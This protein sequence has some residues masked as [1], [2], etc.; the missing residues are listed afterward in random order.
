MRSYEF[1]QDKH[2]KKDDDTSESSSS[3]SAP[4]E[5]PRE[6]DMSHGGDHT[7]ELRPR[8]IEAFSLPTPL[9]R[10][11]FASDAQH[12]ET[13]PDAD[14]P[15]SYEDA[16]ALSHE[17]SA[18]SDEANQSDEDDDE[19]GAPKTTSS[20][21]TEHQTP[22]RP[23]L[24]HASAIEQIM[25]RLDR[26]TAKEGTADF[27][28]AEQEPV[29]ADHPVAEQPAAAPP[30]QAESE[31]FFLPNPGPDAEAVPSV[32]DASDGE[33]PS[34][35]PTSAEAYY[36]P[37]QP[38]PTPQP[39]ADVY[40]Y[41]PTFAQ[42]EQPAEMRFSVAPPPG[43]TVEQ[44]QA[45][46]NDASRLGEKRG[47]RRGLVVGLTALLIAQHL[48]HRKQRRALEQIDQRDKHINQL[49]T[50]Q[51][52]TAEQLQAQRQANANANYYGQPLQAAS[53][54]RP[55]PTAMFNQTPLERAPALAAPRPATEFGP[56]QP[57]QRPEAAPTP[58]TASQEQQAAEHQEGEEIVLQPGQHLERRGWYSVV[59]DEHGREVQ[60]AIQYGEAFQREQRQEQPPVSV[61][62]QTK[63]GKPQ[64][65][66]SVGGAATGYLFGAAG[67]PMISSGQVDPA[68]G[69]PSGQSTDINHRLQVAQPKNPVVATL[70][71]PWL[72]AGVIVLLVAFFAAALL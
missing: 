46:L 40:M 39:N 54:E 24:A 56:Q 4:S 12:A 2:D 50:A 8:R 31:S 33:P 44:H 52:V 25:R 70:T 43:I 30:V 26:A 19:E 32:P 60:G 20:D 68:H 45:E 61:T 18:E 58:Q 10:E 53:S 21:S 38:E 48:S 34:K 62:D 11:L 15:R 13:A 29:E 67:T 64:D 41:H 9:L 51:A 71:S 55:A 5:K 28:P 1:G 6:L 66:Q 17:Q 49:K 14:N 37:E 35:P 7:L 47:L 36:Y 16:T 23:R 57:E 42:Q 27:A 72:W 59:V 3:S 63:K 22:P 65:Y 69:L